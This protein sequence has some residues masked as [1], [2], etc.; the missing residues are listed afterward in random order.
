VD[1]QI[2]VF[3]TSA[4]GGGEWSASRP[5]RFIPEERA[6]DTHWI[7]NWVDPR[8][9]L[10]DMEKLKFLN[11]PGLELRPFGRG[12]RKLSLYLLDYQGSQYSYLHITRRLCECSVTETWLCKD[13]LLRELQI[14]KVTFAI[15]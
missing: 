4:L 6:T 1:V 14:P 3:L 13:A 11:L 5:C 2:R 12:V 15:H 8:A 9:G 10:D 7:G